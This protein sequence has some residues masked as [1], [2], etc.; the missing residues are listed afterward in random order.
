MRRGF[1]KRSRRRQLLG[2]SFDGRCKI[3]HRFSI[4]NAVEAYGVLVGSAALG[5]LLE[6]PVQDDVVLRRSTIAI[7]SYPLPN[8]SRETESEVGV[9]PVVGFMGAGN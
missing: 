5:I 9:M 6:Y 2:D 7:A 1:F 3:S 4:D 8:P